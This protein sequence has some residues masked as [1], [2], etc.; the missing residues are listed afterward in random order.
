[1]AESLIAEGLVDYLGT[2]IH[3]MS[4]INAIDEYLRSKKAERHFHDLAGKLRNDTDF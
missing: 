1:M 3:R 4:H 2:D